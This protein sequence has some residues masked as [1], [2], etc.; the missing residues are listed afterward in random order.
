MSRKYKELT[1]LDLIKGFCE[2]VIGYGVRNGLGTDGI[3]IWMSEKLVKVLELN[4]FLLVKHNNNEYKIPI[5]S[6][7]FIKEIPLG[8]NMFQ[9]DIYVGDPEWIIDL[10]KGE[11]CFN[12]VLR[13]N[14]EDALY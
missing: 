8:N 14:K 4:D 10:A 6:D 12:D 9:T 2:Q 5:I 7:D 11:C 1:G 13:R 3:K